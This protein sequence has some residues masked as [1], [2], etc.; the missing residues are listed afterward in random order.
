M[1][2]WLR[3]WL[4]RRRP[5]APTP[6]GRPSIVDQVESAG[7]PFN[8]LSGHRDIALWNEQRAEAV[9]ADLAGEILVDSN[10]LVDAEDHR[11]DAYADHSHDADPWRDDPRAVPPHGAE[12]TN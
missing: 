6:H 8:F 5:P 9:R 4:Y 11:L 10:E 2:P 1:F 12:P 3:R 7:A